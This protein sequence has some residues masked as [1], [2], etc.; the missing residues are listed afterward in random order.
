MAETSG[1]KRNRTMELNRALSVMGFG[2]WNN[3]EPGTISELFRVWYSEF[4]TLFELTS[5]FSTDMIKIEEQSYF[6]AH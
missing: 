1:P 2:T 5:K 4:L 6:F 3:L